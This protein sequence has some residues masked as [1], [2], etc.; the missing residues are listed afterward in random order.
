MIK[1]YFKRAPFYNAL[2]RSWEPFPPH[3]R[4]RDGLAYFAGGRA[5]WKT[6]KNPSAKPARAAIGKGSQG[7]KPRIC[8]DQAFPAAAPAQIIPPTI[9]T[10]NRRRFRIRFKSLESTVVLPL[11]A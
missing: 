5:A 9:D 4:W 3:W 6:T 10:M 7:W 11:L 2:L 8:T 1:I